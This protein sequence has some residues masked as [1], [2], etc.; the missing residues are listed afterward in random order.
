M[1]SWWRLLLSA[2]Y[3]PHQSCPFRHALIERA[4][5]L[6]VFFITRVQIYATGNPVFMQP[7]NRAVQEMPETL[8]ELQALVSDNPNQEAR[9]RLIA[10]KTRLLMAKHAEDERLIRGGARDR[11]VARMEA[12]KRQM[13]DV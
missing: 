6:G 13:D 4:I 11:A 10:D 5:L 8:R 7:Y 2:M 1:V 12:G 9:V 3:R